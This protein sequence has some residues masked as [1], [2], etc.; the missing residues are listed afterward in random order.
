M[1]VGSTKTRGLTA[2]ADVD[3]LA[4]LLPDLALLIHR[5]GTLLAH[6]GGNTLHGKLMDAQSVGVKIDAALPGELAVRVTQSVR[7]CIADRSPVESE[8]RVNDMNCEVRAQAVGPNRAVV[9]IRQIPEL[10]RELDATPPT[11]MTAHLDR[12][13]FSRRLRQSLAAAAL[14]GRPMAIAV[15]QVEG[16]ADITQALDATLA[17]QAV[18][19]ALARLNT[20]E[21]SH[22]VT[23]DW[24]L[25]QLSERF[26]VAV[27][28]TRD[29]DRI[30]PCVGRICAAFRAPVRVGDSEFQLA[31][32]A[33][34]AILGQDASSAKTLLQH[35]RAAATE[36][37]RSGS[38][39]VFFFSDTMQLRV[40]SRLD[41]AQELREAIRDSDLRLRY[42]G[43][44]DL[45]TGRLTSIVSYV[46]WTDSLRGEVAPADF[47]R[48]AEATGTAHALSR[49]LLDGLRRDYPRL[50]AQ[51]GED[52]GVSFGPL[53]HHVLGD[54]FL[55]DIEAVLASG[56]IAPGRLEI[57]ISERVYISR[58]LKFWHALARTGVRLVVDEIGR[59]LTSL[60]RLARG[61]LWG[62]Q[63]DRSWVAAV[64]SDLTA[65][66]L[67][68]G[69]VQLFSGLQLTSIAAGLDTADRCELLA[70]FGCAE[71]IGDVFSPLGVCEP[72]LDPR[73]S[74][75]GSAAH[76]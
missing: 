75:T 14:S 63:L 4:T 26:L 50:A 28:D 16:A 61:P 3:E 72:S 48:V 24:Y 54:T 8:L 17:D 10:G 64:D 57:R 65:R 12:R 46:H 22:T 9:V 37:Q 19:A 34:V 73:I 69:A 1:R 49:S 62:A 43:R 11:Q 2:I 5:N 30:E 44:H 58:D 67:C 7:K 6:L 20:P 60:D 29:R 53:R 36:A 13:G 25:G 45:K 41:A 21:D 71:G 39:R 70:S 52:V 31:A 15:I 33:G 76:E 27:L 35:A 18:S 32:Y 59:D 42:I 74:A 23:P 51:V 68:R 55:G 66:K 47:L 40:L 38:E 56:D